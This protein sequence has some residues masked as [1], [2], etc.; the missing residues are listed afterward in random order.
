MP[1]SVTSELPLPQIRMGPA[2]SI[3]PEAILGD[4]GHDWRAVEIA[5]LAAL[6]RLPDT[7]DTAV[8]WFCE[9]SPTDDDDAQR[10]RLGLVFTLGSEGLEAAAA[11]LH[12]ALSEYSPAWNYEGIRSLPRRAFPSL[13]SR[14]G[15]IFH[16][17]V[18]GRRGTTAPRLVIEDGELLRTRVLSREV[19]PADLLDGVDEAVGV[20]EAGIGTDGGRMLDAYKLVFAL[21]VCERIL[22]S[23]GQISEGE[24]EFLRRTFPQAR[25]ERLGL[26]DRIR[27]LL[28]RQHAAAELAASM[29]E[30]EKM[31]LMGLFWR[32]GQSDGHIG[33]VELQILQDAAAQLHLDWSEVETYLRDLW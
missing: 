10:P 26:H 9:V 27:F 2:F 16:L 5:A 18:L 3:P 4:D 23:D 25:L 28:L 6:Q 13:G 11:A 29:P 20:D 12:E 7:I 1:V 19:D 15:A 22:E 21:S 33:P 32:A 14:G 24:E 8:A 17:W 30:D 31:V